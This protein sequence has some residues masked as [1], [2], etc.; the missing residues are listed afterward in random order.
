MLL[1]AELKVLLKRLRSDSN[2][3][4]LKEGVSF[5]KEQ[6]MI[7]EEREPLYRAAADLVCDTTR[8]PPQGTVLEIIEFFKNKSWL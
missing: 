4:P 7:L 5:E 2:R 3:P 1:K 6:Q 8:K